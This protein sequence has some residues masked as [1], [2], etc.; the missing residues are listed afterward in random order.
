MK[1]TMEHLLEKKASGRK[2]AML[3]CYDYRM[4]A[5]Q[6]EAGI[7]IVFVGDSVGTNVLG[8]ESETEVSLDEILYHLKMVRRG[9]R[10]AYLLADMPYRTYEEPEAAWE[11]ARRLLAYGADGVKLEGVRPAIVAYLRE[12]G[13]EVCAH[14]GYN[15]QFHQKAAVQGKT[16]EEAVALIDGALDLQ[17]AGAS[18]M[19][20][21]LVPEELAG[22]VTKRLSIPTIGIAAGRYTDGQV[23]SVN[24]MLGLNPRRFRHAKTYADMGGQAL[25]AMRAYAAEVRSGDFPAE[26]NVRHMP[27]AELRRVIERLR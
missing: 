13:I 9:V 21:E 1:T 6:E 10:D 14:I 3:T 20:I 26:S 16:F 8:Y 12:R 11:T 23:L 19:V 27:E 24:D 22:I 25:E 2:I 5:W 17:S 7:D 4:A 18:M 15:P